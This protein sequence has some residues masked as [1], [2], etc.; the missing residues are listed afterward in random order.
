MVA[1]LTGRVDPVVP[2]GLSPSKS[3]PFFAAMLNKKITPFDRIG[4]NGAGVLLVP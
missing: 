3:L 2:L 4:A 1:D